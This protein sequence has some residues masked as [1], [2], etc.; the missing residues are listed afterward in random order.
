[1]G[2]TLVHLSFAVLNFA[3]SFNPIMLLGPLTNY[4]FL[5]FVGGD[6]QTE[7]SQEVRYQVNDPQK[8]QQLRKWR[9]EKNS[10]WPSLRDLK[11]PWALAAVGSGLIGVV[12][13]EVLRTTLVMR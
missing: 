10:F 11:N 8:Y 2:D 6:K 7:E 9:Q 1:L 3:D 13:E 4:V 12:V 5:R